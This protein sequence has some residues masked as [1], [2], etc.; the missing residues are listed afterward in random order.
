MPHRLALLSLALA[1]A[2]ALT[3]CAG[4]NTSV[5]NFKGTEHDVAQAIADFQSAGQRKNQKK[6]CTELLTAEF[7]NSLR[8][9]RS[10]CE[11]EVDDA[12]A[13]ADDYKLTVKDVS[14]SG[15]SAT[16]L[17]ENAGRTVTFHLQRVGAAW[18]IA[19]LGS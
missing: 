1:A 12:M 8:A 11:D 17:V 3:G 5:R 13:D 10:T 7:A 19:S 6:I 4:A 16:A 2:A 9:G 14:V 15:A 18:R